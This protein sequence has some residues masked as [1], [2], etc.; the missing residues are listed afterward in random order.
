[1]KRQIEDILDIM[2]DNNNSLR[3]QEYSKLKLVEIFEKWDVV[4]HPFDIYSVCEEWNY[5]NGREEFITNLFDV[6][7]EKLNS[8]ALQQIY[9][10]L[11]LTADGKPEE[12]QREVNLNNS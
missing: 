8:E 5:N 10:Y 6:Y 4:V 12:A 9:T 7:L 1:V 11:E 3:N 2:Q